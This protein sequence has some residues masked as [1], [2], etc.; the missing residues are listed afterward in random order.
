M[1]KTNLHFVRFE[2]ENKLV[3][4]SVHPDAFRFPHGNGLNVSI[5]IPMHKLI[6]QSDSEKS[7]SSQFAFLAFKE[8]A[9]YYNATPHLI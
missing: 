7:L 3:S 8:G 6:N 2:I 9:F 5:N 1:C 4:I